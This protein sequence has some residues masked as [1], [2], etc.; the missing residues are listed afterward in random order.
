MARA[1]PLEERS[2]PTGVRGGRSS[3]WTPRDGERRATRSVWRTPECS[4]QWRCSTSRWTR[5]QSTRRSTTKRTKWLKTTTRTPSRQRCSSGRW[6]RV[7]ALR[8]SPRGQQAGLRGRS[9]E[10]P[11]ASARRQ[12]ADARPPSLAPT[13]TRNPR[14]WARGEAQAHGPNQDATTAAKEHPQRGTATRE[15]PFEECRSAAA[16][17]QHQLRWCSRPGLGMET[18]PVSRWPRT[19]RRWLHGILTLAVRLR[20]SQIQPQNLSSLR[21]VPLSEPLTLQRRP[22]PLAWHRLRALASL[23]RPAPPLRVLLLLL[24]LLSF[25]HHRHRRR[26]RLQLRRRRRRRSRRQHLGLRRRWEYEHPHL[27]RRPP[28]L[29]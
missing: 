7:D 5:S 4:L 26:R 29:G 10:Q 18:G 22:R 11:R 27:R 20:P 24:L 19:P 15:T 25:H 17:L 14:A 12:R 2:A 21:R 13:K 1:H 3:G 8:T 6:A 9:A 23:S 16:A 28:L